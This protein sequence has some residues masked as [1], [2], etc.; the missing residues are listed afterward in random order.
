MGFIARKDM[1]VGV[2]SQLSVSGAFYAQQRITSSKQNELA[3]TFVS[4][5]YSMTNVPHMYQVPK[6]V[7]NLPPGMPRAA[8][9]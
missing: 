1:S 6:L 3:G 5:Y 8:P 4:S 9:C 7:D 2:S